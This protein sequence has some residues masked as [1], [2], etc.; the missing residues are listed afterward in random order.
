MKQLIVV[1]DSS[2]SLTSGQKVGPAVCFWVAYVYD[3]SS[4]ATH[5]V[6]KQL[7]EEQRYKSAILM[8][9]SK[10]K[11]LRSGAIFNSVDGPTK[12]FYDGIIR[13]LESCF[14]LVKK[15]GFSEAYVVGDCDHA[16]KQ[17]NGKINV[18]TMAPMYNQVKK[19]ESGYS[20]VGVKLFYEYV[21]EKQFPLYQ[22]LDGVGKEIRGKIQ[23]TF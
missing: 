13:A 15:E 3:P 18:N 17:L 6:S 7:P 12:I 23:G 19:W 21:N 16:I 4:D 22:K 14:Y 1:L 8:E 2:V 11:P 9:A 10:S 5:P 20:K